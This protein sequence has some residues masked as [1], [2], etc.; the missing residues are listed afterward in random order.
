MNKEIIDKTAKRFM[1]VSAETCVE[2][3]VDNFGNDE[4]VTTESEYHNKVHN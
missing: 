3:I 4:V 1:A 2:V